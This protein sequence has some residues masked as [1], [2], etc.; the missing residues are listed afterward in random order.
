MKRGKGRPSSASISCGVWCLCPSI[1]WRRKTWP[2]SRLGRVSASHLATASLRSPPPLHLQPSRSRWELAYNQ[3][4]LELSP[5]TLSVD[6]DVGRYGRS[7][8]VGRQALHWRA[9]RHR[10]SSFRDCGATEMLHVHHMDRNPANNDPANL[11]TLCGSCHLKL[12][13]REDRPSGVGM[14]QRSAAGS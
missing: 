4:G 7:L 2:R 8:T 12:H 1:L 13:W 5:C 3:R 11:V 14:R 9:R 10:A 6:W